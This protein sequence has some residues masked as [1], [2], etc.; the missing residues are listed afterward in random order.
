M[1]DALSSWAE[2]IIVAVIIASL[3]EMLLPNGNNK[4]YIKTVIGVY[5]LFTIISPILG[6]ITNFDL[7]EFDY[8][9]YFKNT[10]TY[11]AMSESLTSKNDESVEQIY[12]TNLKQDMTQKLK[13]KG[14][15]AE[16]ITIKLDLDEGDNYGRLNNIY[17]SVSTIEDTKD[18]QEAQEGNTILNQVEI[19][20]VEKVSIGNKTTNTLTQESKK[21]TLSNSQKKEIKKYLASVY[22]VKEKN[23]TVNEEE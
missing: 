3:I 18:A 21:S 10:D 2:Q 16:K 17:L 20:K 9:A 15:Q 8:E 14:Y 13:E 23:I 5:I 11:Q 4:K 19:S 6:K 22:E 12:I 7:K 1:I